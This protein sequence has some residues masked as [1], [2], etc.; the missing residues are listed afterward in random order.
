[1]EIER[2]IIVPI[3]TFCLVLAIVIVSFHS[4]IRDLQYWNIEALKLDVTFFVIS[5]ISIIVMS[6]IGIKN[7]K[8]LLQR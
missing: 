6:H 4:M 5:L 8:E 3:V 2:E 1:M 7:R